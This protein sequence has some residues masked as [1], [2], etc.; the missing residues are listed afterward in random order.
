MCFFARILEC[1]PPLPRQHSAAIC[2][3]K[4]YQPIG[5]TVHSNCVESFEDLLQRCRRGWGY[6]EM[7]KNTIFPEHPVHTI[8]NTYF[9]KYKLICISFAGNYFFMLTIK[10]LFPWLVLWTASSCLPWKWKLKVRPLVYPPVR[11][12]VW[13]IFLIVK[14]FAMFYCFL[15]PPSMPW[16]VGMAAA[17]FKFPSRGPILIILIINN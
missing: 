10:S 17:N 16:A 13:I 8:Y 3:T 4:N 7:W 5:V 6:S 12:K 11:R 2:C 15:K 9:S 1:L 14:F